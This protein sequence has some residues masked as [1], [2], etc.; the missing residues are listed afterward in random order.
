MI[1]LY[2]LFELIIT[3]ISNWNKMKIKKITIW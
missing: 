2:K 1:M 3:K